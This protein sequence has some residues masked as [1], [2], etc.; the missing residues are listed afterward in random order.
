MT[1]IFL[2]FLAGVFTTL[3]PCVLPM[4]P[5]VMAS[6]L[7]QSRHGPLAL[8]GGL[9]VSFTALGLLIAAAGFAVG[10]DSHSLRIAA[11]S[12]MIA[13][14]VILFSTSLQLRLASALGPLAGKADMA[15]SESGSLGLKGQF[16]TGLLMGAVWAP[17]SGPALGAAISLAAESGGVLPAGVRLLAY[18]IGAGSILALLAYG[19][20]AAIASR[21]E[22]FARLSQYAKPVMATVFVA[23]GLAIIFGIDKQIEMIATNLM[24]EWLAEITTRF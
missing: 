1:A 21:K 4:I 19:S 3:N 5:I 23:L 9:V 18:G 11:A 6:S 15:I 7:E 8:A 17:C 22:R 16:I 24:P 2:S 14:G 12:M 10:L 20:R 13:A